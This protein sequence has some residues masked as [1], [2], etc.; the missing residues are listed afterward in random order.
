MW[1]AWLSDNGDHHHHIGTFHSFEAACE[2]MD[3]YFGCRSDEIP[4][5]WEGLNGEYGYLNEGE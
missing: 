3:L 1:T 4:L 5:G 2:W